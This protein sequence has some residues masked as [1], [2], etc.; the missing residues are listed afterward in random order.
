MIP[1]AA[2]TMFTESDGRHRHSHR[3]TVYSHARCQVHGGRIRPGI[4]DSLAL[5]HAPP[6]KDVYPPS[7]AFFQ[8]LLT[9]QIRSGSSTPGLRIWV[10]SELSFIGRVQTSH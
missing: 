6:C 7:A 8:H 9:E 1:V 2:L 4:I 5:D 10:R 3:Q